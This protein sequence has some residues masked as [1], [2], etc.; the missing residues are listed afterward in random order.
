MKPNPTPLTKEQWKKDLNILIKNDLNRMG[1]AIIT[2]GEEDYKPRTTL[3]E[4]LIRFIEKIVIPQAIKQERSRIVE[5]LKLIIDIDLTKEL[6]K[7]IEIYNGDG[8][9]ECK[10]CGTDPI[11]QREF[12]LKALD[13]NER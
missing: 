2:W 7:N 10:L 1:V 5:K 3:E 13:N 8:S 4:E 12:L 6:A 11:R 9:T